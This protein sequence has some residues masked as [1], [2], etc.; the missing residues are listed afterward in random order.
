MIISTEWLIIQT[1]EVNPFFGGF[2]TDSLNF[3]YNC[4]G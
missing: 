4:R 1:I 2:F 3:W